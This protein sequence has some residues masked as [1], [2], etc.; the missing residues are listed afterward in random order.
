MLETDS[1]VSSGNEK[2]KAAEKQEN[3]ETEES[4]EGVPGEKD[5]AKNMQVLKEAISVCRMLLFMDELK[6][7]G[8]EEVPVL[9]GKKWIRIR[10]KKEGERDFSALTNNEVT[11]GFLIKYSEKGGDASVIVVGERPDV[12]EEF[13]ESGLLTE[14]FKRLGKSGVSITYLVKEEFSF[15]EHFYPS[16]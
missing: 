14:R 9:L 11:G 1:T 13:K 2:E 10:L 5:P 3:P 16:F 7:R 12:L 8:Y 4:K 6:D 15:A